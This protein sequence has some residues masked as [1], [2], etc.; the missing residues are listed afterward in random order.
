MSTAVGSDA[1]VVVHGEEII[2]I[3]SYDQLPEPGPS[4]TRDAEIAVTVED[5][6]QRKELVATSLVRSSR[7]RSAAA[8]TRSLR[9]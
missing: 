7:W 9:S 8:S 5:A 4:G 1:L 2:A 6:W 3:A